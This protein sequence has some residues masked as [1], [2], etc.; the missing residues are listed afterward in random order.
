VDRY[1]F[2]ILAAQIFF[3]PKAAAI[4]AFLDIIVSEDAMQAKS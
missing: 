2:P 4:S 1:E 3:V